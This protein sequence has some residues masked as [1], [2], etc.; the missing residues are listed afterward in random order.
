MQNKIRSRKPLVFACLLKSGKL[1][2]IK[3]K[4]STCTHTRTVYIFKCTRVKQKKLSKKN[5]QI[6]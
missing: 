4:L 6:C 3:I 2:I 5:M 1:N